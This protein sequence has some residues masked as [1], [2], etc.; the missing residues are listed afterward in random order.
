MKT[1]VHVFETS[2]D[3]V[4]LC[5]AGGRGRG[6]QRATWSV[7][8]LT[9]APHHALQPLNPGVKWMN[10]S[11][12]GDKALPMTPIPRRRVL[13]RVRASDLIR[14]TGTRPD[15]RNN[16][17]ATHIPPAKP[18]APNTTPASMPPIAKPHPPSHRERAREDQDH[19]A[20]TRTA[21]GP[22]ICGRC[23]ES[24]ERA[25]NG[26]RLCC[27]STT[28]S[29]TAPCCAASAWLSHCTSS[30]RKDEALSACSRPYPYTPASLLAEKTGLCNWRLLASL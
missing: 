27:T 10:T 8:A 23:A 5:P 24:L 22:P 7:L 29:S 12:S 13:W 20:W 26:S 11:S 18:T 19:L 15:A 4:P 6:G 1:S 2:P 3:L 9:Q 21:P 30:Q 14:N 16:L 28:E 25:A 17:T